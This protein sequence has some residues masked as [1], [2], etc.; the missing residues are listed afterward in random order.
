MGKY[1]LDGRYGSHLEMFGINVGEAL[2]EAGAPEDL[3]SRHRPTLEEAA[4]YRFMGAVGS[5]A[6]DPQLPIR[7][8]SADG[9]ESFSPPLFAAYC[10]ENAKTCCERL[11]EYKRIIAPM[12]YRTTSTERTVEVEMA[13]S[14]VGLSLPQFL[15]ESE[16][17]FLLHIIR[18]ATRTVIRPIQIHM[19]DPPTTGDLSRYARCPI[20]KSGRNR[21][22]FQR[23]DMDKPFISYNEGMWDY[24]A[25]ELQRR[26]Y[27]MKEGD[28]A[29]MKVRSAL[30]G[31]LPSG[32]TTIKDVA[33]TL[34]ISP[35]TLER[36]LAKENTTFQQQ[37][38][39]TRELLAKHYI[40]NTDM[41]S[42]DIAFLL[43]Y[44]ESNSF[45]RAFTQWTGLSVSE[46]KN[47]HNKPRIK[48][49]QP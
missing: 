28:P 46:Y 38:N 24:L 11:S 33:S 23:T 19:T 45:L 15:V 25:P 36:R 17:V 10:S 48:P 35:R 34:G 5:Q 1:V 22:I 2:R 9:V 44:Q 37:L 3:F 6:K 16:M 27:E 32:R 14:G 21:I 31:L 4:Y 49:Q 12:R 18:A 39:S 30:T 20:R 29:A 42:G 8:A 47:H 40:R 26:L 7:I 43:G 41:S 13:A